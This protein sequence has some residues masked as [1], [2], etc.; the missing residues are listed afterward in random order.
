MKAFQAMTYDGSDLAEV[1]I[2]AETMEAAAL[3]VP[4]A[5]AILD[6]EAEAVALERA[7]QLFAQI[8]AAMR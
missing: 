4:A 5:I 2:N 6:V 1:I 3:A 8:E 7:L